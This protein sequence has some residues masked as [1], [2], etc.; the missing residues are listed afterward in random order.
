[1]IL[2]SH[3]HD[4][5][6]SSFD[7]AK[8]FHCS[9][10]NANMASTSVRATGCDGLSLHPGHVAGGSQADQGGDLPGSA[11]STPPGGCSP[12]GAG[13]IAYTG[14]RDHDADESTQRAGE[15]SHPSYRRDG[16]T[17][18]GMAGRPS[19]D[20]GGLRGVSPDAGDGVRRNASDFCLMCPDNPVNVKA[21]VKGRSF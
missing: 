10:L 13:I 1:M 11:E 18:G 3:F 21:E 20:R 7:R 15:S 2:V 14:T 12:Q 19:R 17:Q 9:I 5:S 6:S 16:T 8:R 4:S